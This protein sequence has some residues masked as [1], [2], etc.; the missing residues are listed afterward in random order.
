MAVLIEVASCYICGLRVELYALYAYL[1]FSIITL[2]RARVVR[3]ARRIADVGF[4]Y[5]NNK[6]ARQ[7][8]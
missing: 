5:N 3:S 8:T 2:A 1:Y 7:N 6:K 4:N